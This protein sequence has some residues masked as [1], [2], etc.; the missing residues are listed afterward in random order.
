MT[1]TARRLWQFSRQASATPG[2]QATLLMVV[3]L[4]AFLAL[5]MHKFEPLPG[6]I[7]FPPAWPVGNVISG[8]QVVRFDAKS[9]AEIVVWSRENSL[10]RVQKACS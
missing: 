2:P 1:V 10:L 6:R 5:M 8:L 7:Y 3:A 9:N 4:I